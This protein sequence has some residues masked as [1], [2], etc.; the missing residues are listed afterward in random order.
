MNIAFDLDGVIT[1][2]YEFYMT[3]AKPFFKKNYNKDIV[4]PKAFHIEEVFDCSPKE[5]RSFWKRYIL[6]Y[7]TKYPARKNAKEI[8][9]KL[10][11]EGNNIYIITSRIYTNNQNGIGKLARMLVKNWLKDNGIMYDNIEFCSLDEYGKVGS[12]KKYNID[13][14]VEDMPGN[15]KILNKLT[16]TICFS[17]PYNE[18][19]VCDG[20]PKVNNFLEVYQEIKKI[21][22]KKVKT[23]GKTI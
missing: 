20:V 13:V 9:K 21:E 17:N 14:I 11:D 18:D 3:Y 19:Y 12:I 10:H 7:F 6:I 15:I 1:D 16:K 2:L 4:N 23:Y 8:I 5:A 22:E